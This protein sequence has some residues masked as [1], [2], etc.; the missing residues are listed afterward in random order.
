MRCLAVRGTDRAVVKLL[1]LFYWRGHEREKRCMAILGSE[2]FGKDAKGLT[3]Q[4]LNNPDFFMPM[5]GIERKGMQMSGVA[6]TGMDN[7]NNITKG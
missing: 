3:G 7:N 4:S 1:G 2:R 6:R 5:H